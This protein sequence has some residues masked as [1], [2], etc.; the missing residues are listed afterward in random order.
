MKRA[1]SFVKALAD[2]GVVTGSS[3]N[4][5]IFP[6]YETRDVQLNFFNE[7]QEASGNTM[8]YDADHRYSEITNIVDAYDS[9]S[10]GL[11]IKHYSV[12][13]NEGIRV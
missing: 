12:K 5:K 6:V 8:L 11:N 13:N 3:S 7:D 10:S 9:K 2:K 4:I 1:R